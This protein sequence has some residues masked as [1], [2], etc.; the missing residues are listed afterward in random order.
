M[1]NNEKPFIPNELKQF[2]DLR[3]VDGEG[4]DFYIDG[5]RFLPENVTYS[6]VLAKA[7]TFDHNT[8][9]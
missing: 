8:V 5:A 3:F 9:I 2:N 1:P 7:L 4:I 6:R